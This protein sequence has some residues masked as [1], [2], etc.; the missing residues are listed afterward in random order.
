MTSPRVRPRVNVRRSPAV[1]GS[2][3]FLLWD[4]RMKLAPVALWLL[5]AG[6]L[7]L[8][9]AAQAAPG[10]RPVGTVVG[11]ALMPLESS[12]DDVATGR[13]IMGA[14]R[15]ALDTTPGF[16]EK[17]PVEMGL[18]E[19]RMSFSCFDEKPGCM[20]QVGAL[21]D[22]RFL[23]WGKLGR[24]GTRLTLELHLVDVAQGTARNEVFAESEPGAVDRLGRRAAEMVVGPRKPSE[25]ALSVRSLPA[26]ASVTIDGVAMGTTPVDVSLLAGVHTVEL[27]MAGMQ[28][29]RRTVELVAGAPAPLVVDE[30]L[31]ELPANTDAASLGATDETETERPDRGRPTRFWVGVGAAGVAAAAVASAS[32]FGLKAL[33]HK[34]WANKHMGPGDATDAEWAARQDDM[35]AMQLASNVSW[36]VAALA[37][38]ASAFCFLTAS[39]DEG[40]AGLQLIPGPG[41]V[42]LAGR[43]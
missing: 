21:V 4:V 23:L 30:R 3:S 35:K 28:S 33:D 31:R 37:A 7:G 6:L 14:V 1:G 40:N 29:R 2:V 12:P 39:D 15:D 41:A 16:A 20:A 27:K 34:D 42:G 8:A 36:G 13:Q 22:A 5:F 25:A 10:G 19:A 9:T 38:G 11:V 43:F 26:G 17:G 24:A 32:I 18:D